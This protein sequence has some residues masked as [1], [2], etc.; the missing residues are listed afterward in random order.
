MTENQFWPKS[1]KNFF[2]S[3]GFAMGWSGY[4]KHEYYFAPPHKSVA[5]KSCPTRKRHLRFFKTSLFPI[6]YTLWKVNRRTMVEM[7]LCVHWVNVSD[8]YK[9]G[10]SV[11]F[12][13]LQSSYKQKTR[14]PTDNAFSLAIDCKENKV[15][16]LLCP[17]LPVIPWYL[18][19][20]F[21]VNKRKES[22]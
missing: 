2:E 21:H 16:A 3:R 9:S 19:L 1:Q 14:F 4:L 18:T 20:Y 12:A 11:P 10:R 15:W 17:S 5:L 22:G 8:F 13:K 7:L 6:R